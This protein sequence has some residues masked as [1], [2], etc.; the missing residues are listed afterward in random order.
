MFPSI[1]GIAPGVAPR[2]VVSYC[3][4]REMPFREWNFAFRES[5]SEFRDLRIENGVGK[6]GYGN[7]PP[8]DDRNRYGN[9]VSTPYTSKTNGTTRPQLTRHDRESKRKADTEI[10]YRPR[11]VDTDIDCGPRFCGPRF[12]DSYE[13]CSENTP[14]RSQ[15]FENGLFTP[16]AFFLKLGWSGCFSLCPF[17]VCP[18]DL[19][20]FWYV[21]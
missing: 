11:I 18:L 12:R 9:S 3:S 6:Q 8:I 5:R 20:N 7:R 15:S 19:F 14:E 10:Q 21:M 2:I 4:S 17:R 13:S 1:P 16:R